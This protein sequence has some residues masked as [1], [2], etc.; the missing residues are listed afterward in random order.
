MSDALDAAAVDAELAA[1]LAEEE[2]DLSSS[3]TCVFGCKCQ[4]RTAHDKRV[5]R[6]K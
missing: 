3:W 6:S 1:A 5:G 4:T 2:E